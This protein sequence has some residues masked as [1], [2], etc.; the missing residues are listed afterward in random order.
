MA[1]SIETLIAGLVSAGLDST[2]AV[3]AVFLCR[4]STFWLPVL[5]GWITFQWLERHEYL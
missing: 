2:V 1:T 5:P 4:L 3:P